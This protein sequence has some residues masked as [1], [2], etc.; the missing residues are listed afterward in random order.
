MVGAEWGGGELCSRGF[1]SGLSRAASPR[2]CNYYVSSGAYS[3]GVFNL[4]L[5]VSQRDP[6]F[7]GGWG[8]SDPRLKVN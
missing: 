7:F 1:S 4:I 2:R 6:H 5:F 3:P 8:R